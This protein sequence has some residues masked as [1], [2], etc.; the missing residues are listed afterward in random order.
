MSALQYMTQPYQDLLIGCKEIGQY[1]PKQAP[2]D[3]ITS[4]KPVLIPFQA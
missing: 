1:Y 3:S 4:C 2:A